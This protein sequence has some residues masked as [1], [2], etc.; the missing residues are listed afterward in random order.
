MLYHSGEKGPMPAE[1]KTG[2]RATE[3]GREDHK[4]PFII[5]WPPS[6]PP[7]HSP[8]ALRKFLKNFVP[9]CPSIRPLLP[10]PSPSSSALFSCPL[11]VRSGRHSWGNWRNPRRP[12]DARF[13]RK[14]FAASPRSAARRWQGL[15]QGGA[16]NINASKH[17]ILFSAASIMRNAHNTNIRTL[18]NRV[19][20]KQSTP[21]TPSGTHL[22]IVVPVCHCGHCLG[23][24]ES[25][26]VLEGLWL[27]LIDSSPVAP[28]VLSVSFYLLSLLFFPHF[29]FQ[30]QF[31]LIHC[32][33]RLSSH[34]YHNLSVISSGV[35]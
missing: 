4:G 16:S 19:I 27:R 6:R 5:T 17:C 3:G 7:K 8:D 26:F 15:L 22:A 24:S 18:M 30:H 10:P 32:L 9:R 14:C 33:S 1:A 28:P 20:Y 21:T 29:L 31:T 25:D 2:D 12:G 23:S 13:P 11:C 35:T 34:S